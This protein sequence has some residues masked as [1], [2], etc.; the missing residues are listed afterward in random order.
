MLR[1]AFSLAIAGV[2]LW[3]VNQNVGTLPASLAVAWWVVPAYLALLLLY[4][5]TRAWRWWF[6]VR[7]LGDA[8]MQMT[9]EVA[10]TGFL[11][12]IL[13]PW[14]LGELARP[15]LL[16]QKTSI[17]APQILG[18]VAIERVVDGLTVCGVFFATL[19]IHHASAV[20]VEPAPQ[21][22]EI[23]AIA[24]SV[25]GLFLSALALLVAMA[26]WPRAIGAAVR[27]ALGRIHGSLAERL[28]AVADGVGAGLR[29]MPALGP[30]AR[31]L[32]ANALYWA[33][34]A[35]GMWMLARGCG[36]DLDLVETASVM[37]IINL[38][39]LVPGAPGHLGTFQLGVL[40]G[41]ALYTPPAAMGDAG[42][43]FAF[44]LYTTQIG[45]CVVLGVWAGNRLGIAWRPLLDR[46]IGGGADESER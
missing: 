20:G 9:V 11:W 41:L 43:R 23:Q 4:F 28:G 2:A 33:I 37:T 17:P 38:A 8:P 3:L 40:G 39:L 42:L 31:F 22:A 10:L 27:A 16:A 36:L 32:A 34:N 45:V 13:L 24:G 5:F 1:L 35:V 6:L 19:A 21:S 14:R 29:A 18:T 46:L 30:I 44:Y 12:I 7:A 15:L 25:S 26:L